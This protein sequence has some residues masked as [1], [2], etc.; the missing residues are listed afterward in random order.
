MQVSKETV[1]AMLPI[2]LHVH[3][4]HPET[5]PNAI[6]LRDE[7]I[8]CDE[9]EKMQRKPEKSEDILL[10]EDIFQMAAM[11]GQWSSV[12]EPEEVFTG[13]SVQAMGDIIEWA[14]EFNAK[15]KGRVWDGEWYD[16][17]EEFFNYKINKA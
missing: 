14:K 7:L 17:L 4:M 12:H 9:R 15:N 6:E 8:R 10:H 3:E 2:L 1:A 16:E 11:F 5:W 13:G